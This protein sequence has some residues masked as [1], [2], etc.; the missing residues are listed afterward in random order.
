MLTKS[1]H[2]V[3]FKSCESCLCATTAYTGHV[4]GI[5]HP[6]PIEADMPNWKYCLLA[7][8]PRCTYMHRVGSSASVYFPIISRNNYDI[9]RLCQILVP[10]LCRPCNVIPNTSL[11][12]FLIPEVD[13]THLKH[14]LSESVSWGYRY[15]LVSRCPRWESQSWQ[16]MIPITNWNNGDV[17][18]SAAK[19]VERQTCRAILGVIYT[20]EADALSIQG[21][22]C[23]SHGA[24]GF[25]VTQRHFQDVGLRLYTGKEGAF[26]QNSYSMLLSRI[27]TSTK[28]ELG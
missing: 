24:I 25:P 5:W 26:F 10:K 4:P 21:A 3:E 16:H 20:L 7:L 23:R 22:V 15:P 2:R 8:G 17:T 19:A 13:P 28:A 14:T 18:I 27:C 9:V 11:F 6:F 12:L 1:D